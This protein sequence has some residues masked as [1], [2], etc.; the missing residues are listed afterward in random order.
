M[1]L[2]QCFAD[3]KESLERHPYLAFI[4]E[5][6]ADSELWSL[7]EVL[8]ILR[9]NRD[10]VIREVDRCAYRQRATGMTER[11]SKAIAFSVRRSYCK[12]PLKTCPINCNQSIRQGKDAQ[13]IL[14]R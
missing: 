5:N 11:R 14:L 12:I 1:S 10:W 9:R 4:V 6:P 7:P 13:Q 2:I 3:Q 8:K